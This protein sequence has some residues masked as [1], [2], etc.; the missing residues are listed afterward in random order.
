MI[1]DDFFSILLLEKKSITQFNQTFGVLFGDST[2][3]IANNLDRIEKLD[4][5]CQNCVFILKVRYFADNN[6][7]AHLVAILVGPKTVN[8]H[9]VST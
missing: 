3:Q 1:L 4:Q 7:D 8:P 2:S 6:V 9:R 5:F